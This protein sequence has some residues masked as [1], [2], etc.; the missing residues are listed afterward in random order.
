MDQASLQG[1]PFVVD[2]TPH[3]A[4]DWDP[5]KRNRDFLNGVDPRHYEFL[6][7]M[8]ETA[9]QGEEAQHAALA[10]RTA[11]SRALETLF[12]F[13]GATVQ[14]PDCVA[15]WLTVYQNRELESL[16]RKIHERRRVLSVWDV[17]RI[18]WRTLSDIVHSSLVIDD[19]EK[20]VRVK[21][22]F[23]ALWGRFAADFLDVGARQEYNSIKHGSRARPGGFYL[24]I[25]PEDVQGVPAA[26]ER[27]RLL[28]RSEYGS[29]FP[30]LERVGQ[31]R[32]HLRLRQH[33]RNWD[34]TDM[35]FGLYLI[36]MS[37]NNI[38][39]FLKTENGVEASAVQFTWPGSEGAFEKPWERRN[40]IRVLSFGFPEPEILDGDIPP[41]SQKQVFARY[42]R[43]RVDDDRA[44]G[45]A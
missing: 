40:L 22:H 16:V 43:R 26:P 41:I 5:I 45:E 4:W 31:E 3:C 12:A 21:R 35:L 44:A 8:Y 27:M 42:R 29:S 9:L 18:T 17:E 20:E 28:G 25:G 1:C 36:A 24:A 37:L 11:Y 38:I 10:I 34:P 33:S 7:Q 19:K 23:G 2:E 14:A 13:L 39:A 6:T 30:V 15:A 32:M